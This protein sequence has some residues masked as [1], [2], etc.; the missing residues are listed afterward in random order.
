MDGIGLLGIQIQEA[1]T[2]FKE[3]LIALMKWE[4]RRNASTSVAEM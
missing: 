1:L 2:N 4:I 3:A